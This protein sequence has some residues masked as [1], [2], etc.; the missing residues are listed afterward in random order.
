MRN[1][2]A[3]YKGRSENRICKMILFMHFLQ[4]FFQQHFPI[5]VQ[6]YFIQRLYMDYGRVYEN[7]VCIELLRRGYDVYV[8]KL[9][10]R[11]IDF[12]AQE[13]ARRFIFR[14]ATVCG[15]SI[16]RWFK[17]EKVRY[18]EKELSNKRMLLLK[19]YRF[20]KSLSI[21]ILLS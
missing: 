2:T 11:E 6:S 4:F 13:A 8:G 10:Q 20:H 17:A 5:G 3:E 21:Y 14:S 12:V 9:Y 18:A 16:S 1:Y 15:R 19:I 7:I